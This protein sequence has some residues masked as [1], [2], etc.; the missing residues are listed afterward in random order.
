M[1]DKPRWTILTCLA[2]AMLMSFLGSGCGVRFVAGSRPN[3]DVL[4][5]SLRM[6]ESTAADV[7][8]ALGEPSGKGRAML[9]IESKPRTMWSYYYEEGTLEDDRRI[10]LFV[11]FDQDRYNGYM[12]FSSLPK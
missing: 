10:F 5:K 11:Y 4:E 3:I 7:S 9:P 1:R 6:G 8:A 12:W 2:L